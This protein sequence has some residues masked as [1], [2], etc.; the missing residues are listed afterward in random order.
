[1]NQ[2]TIAS[3]GTWLSPI[4]AEDV[5]STSVYLSLWIAQLYT[6]NDVLYALC[7][8]PEQGGRGVVTRI[9]EDGNTEELTPM[10]FSCWT[11]VYEYGG[12]C[13]AVEKG[14]IYF[15]NVPD[16]RLYRHK[17]GVRP[18]PITAEGD[19]RYSD[20]MIDAE[21]KRIICVREDRSPNGEHKHTIAAVNMDGDEYGTVLFEQTDFVYRPKLSPDGK[22]LLWFAWNHPNMRFYV[23]GVWMADIAEDGSLENV[24]NIVVENDE[25]ILTLCW[26]QDGDPIFGSDRDNWWNLYRWRDG[27]IQ[28]LAPMEAE[29]DRPFRST[30][31]G[32]NTVIVTIYR[33]NG[34]RQFGIVNAETGEYREIPTQYTFFAHMAISSEYA[35]TVAASASE[36]L[37]LLRINLQTTEVRVLLRSMERTKYDGYISIPDHIEF[38]TENGLIAHANYYSPTNQNYVAAEDERP[39]VIVNV[40]GGPTSSTNMGFNLGVQF[41]TSRGFA[42]LDVDYGGSTGYGRAYR[43][44]LWGN[45]GMVD[46]DDA[47][48]AAKYLVER[49]LADE[50]RTII[51][52]G[53]AGGF[54]TF[55]ALAFRGYFKAGSSHFGISDL[56]VFHKETHKYESHYCETLI[57]PYP[58]LRDLY[59]ERSPIN[60]IDAITVPLILLQGLDDKVVPP[61]QSQIVVDALLDNGIPVAYIEFEG[62]AHGFRKLETNVVA[63]EAELAFF[64][65]VFDFV[66]TDELPDIEIHNLET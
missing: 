28:R 64:A 21:R 40:H 51:R 54:T 56:E 41:W 1:M 55:A 16:D 3:F 5:A 15:S 58:D 63:H 50:T 65:K 2:K 66:P 42:F 29:L 39:P 52:G 38:P 11:R 19:M 62:E 37:C 4:S 22:K 6:D 20:L 24:Q 48:N 44:R 25:S 36:P 46:V 27:D 10:P 30:K 17:P 13:F 34:R 9:D 57:G 47:I 7:M 14:V 12:P 23:S 59:I 45:W 31:V 26:S 53:S 35:Y 60:K 8:H 32:G 18:E 61:N 43:K 33:Q 49:G